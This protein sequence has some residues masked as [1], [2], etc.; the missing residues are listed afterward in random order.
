MFA[1]SPPAIAPATGQTLL[2]FAHPQNHTG[3]PV[4]RAAKL[5]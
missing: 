1:C 3:E 5:T 4:F 2:N